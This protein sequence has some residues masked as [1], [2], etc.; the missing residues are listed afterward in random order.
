MDVNWSIGKIVEKWAEITPLS[1][2]LSIDQNKYSYSDLNM[3]ANKIANFLLHLGFRKGDRIATLSANSLELV[4]V[5]V[6]SAKLG[7]VYVPLN[8]R[9]LTD[10]LSYQLSDSAC[11]GL[12]CDLALISK[13]RPIIEETD[14]LA[15]NVFVSNV[16]EGHPQNIGDFTLL[17]TAISDVCSKN[18]QLPYP[19]SLAD[20]LAILYT[21][22]TTGTPKGAIVSHLQ[23]YFKCFQVII[24]TDMRQSDKSLTHLPLF[25]SAGLFIA[26]TP[27]LCRGG[28]FISSHH[29][30]AE[31]L[32]NDCKDYAATLLFA[33]TTM[34][35]SVL[36]VYDIATESFSSVRSTI[37][38]GER[39]PTTFISALNAIGLHL[40]QGYGQTENS[41]MTLQSNS[42]SQVDSASVGKPGFFTD[43]WIE[44]AELHNG[45]ADQSGQ[46]LA[47]GPTVMSGYWNMPESTNDTIVDGVL[48]TG[49]I[50]YFNEAGYLFLLDRQKDMYRS[51]GENVYPAEIEKVLLGHEMIIDVA[52]IGVG[53]SKWGEVGAAYI[54]TNSTLDTE[55]L[56]HYLATK[57][58]KY[59]IPKY[60]EFIS[61]LPRTD[62][63]K[64]RKLELCKLFEKRAL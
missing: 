45:N 24:Y 34:L 62:T 54:V 63:G 5:Y 21:S 19:V 10:E 47:S 23:T 18:P 43:V 61:E 30:D 12:V 38:G 35:N 2:A 7:L 42:L 31:R 26:L 60:I 44:Q 36:D 8:N 32:I 53:D 39:T 3:H 57:V 22:G 17:D 20:P 64:I 29:F 55:I 28:L 50:G 59:K 51:G 14:G 49:D 16:T 9:L 13:V 48:K 52:I 56:K 25:H 15:E 1:L 27:T 58:A 33:S 11:K 46:I 6:A 37:G 4:A 40:Q 41:F